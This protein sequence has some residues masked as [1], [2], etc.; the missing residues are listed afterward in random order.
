MAGSVCFGDIVLFAPAVLFIHWHGEES[1][2]SEREDIVDD[3]AVD[4]DGRTVGG[5]SSMSRQKR[6]L[7]EAL[8][9]DNWLAL[10]SSILTP[11]LGKCSHISDQRWAMESLMHDA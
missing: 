8:K 7:T 9:K 2:L 6:P 4:G 11:M 1:N 3:A 5:Y 10:V